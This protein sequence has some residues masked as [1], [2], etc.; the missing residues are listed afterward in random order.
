MNNSDLTDE[1]LLDIY[2]IDVGQGD[3]T[4]VRTPDMRHMLIDG[5][6][7]RQ[8]QQ[9]GKNAADLVDWKFFSDY[10]DYKV[11]LESLMASHS[12][13]DH[14]GGLHD[15]LRTTKQAD[16]ELDCIGVEVDVFHHP[17]LSRW[18][19]VKNAPI[20]HAQ[21]LGPRKSGGFIRLLG[22]RND[23]EGSTNKSRPEQLSGPWASFVKSVLSNSKR[24]KVEPV[25]VAREDIQ[26]L[27]KLPHLWKP[28]S[29]CTIKVLAPV[30]YKVGSKTA[31]KDFGS[32][33]KNTNGHS[34]C[35]Q[36]EY[37]KARIL[38]TGDLNTKS[39]H[40]LEEAFGDRVAIFKC[41]VAKACHHGSHDI[42]YRFLK[43]MEPSATIISSGDAEGHAHP[44]PEVVAASAITG[45]ITVDEVNDKLLT[46]LV[47][48]TEIERSVTLGSI[49]RI[50]VKNMTTPSGPINGTVLGT[51]T[52]EINSMGFV[53]PPKR[54]K[55][56]GITDSDEKRKLADKI[57]ADEEPILQAMEAR[58]ARGTTRVDMNLTVPLG[59]VDKKNDTLRAW[60]AR[61]MQKT[62]YGMVTVRTDGEYIMCA[63]MDE[64]EDD[65][66]I[67]TFK[68]RFPDQEATVA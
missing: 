64:T 53:S 58:T 54:I 12:D 40:W 22:D 37:K 49:N 31:L 6:L 27:K 47:Y 46:P 8:K 30:S 14:Y 23:A 63:T 17:G 16:R 41:D 35:L 57:K 39:M 38:L 1:A 59:P 43:K 33:S 19:N 51:F 56:K 32:K 55:F 5:G 24:T 36:V 68:A 60:R 48:M 62:H 11:R 25:L 65:W 10:G 15:L 21:G 29:G 4:L 28:K 26:N 20:K 7:E 67:H 44:R 66:I 2:F 52:D 42:S 3:G 45:H 18:S 9:T 61:M 13:S 34:I 50:D